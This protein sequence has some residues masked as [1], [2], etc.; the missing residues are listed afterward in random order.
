[1]QHP[2]GSDVSDFRTSSFSGGGACVEIGW[3]R[4]GG[5]V[6]RDTKDP[7]RSISLTFDPDVWASFI[8]AV[9]N[10]LFDE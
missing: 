5:V 9:R 6:M 3:R 1:M 10:G 7:F 8:A 4:D 2:N